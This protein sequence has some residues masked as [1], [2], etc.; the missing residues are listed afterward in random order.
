M[1]AIRP[2]PM[3]TPN[4]SDSFGSILTRGAGSHHHGSAH[5]GSS[6][7]G[8]DLIS[9]D[10]AGAAG[11]VGTHSGHGRGGHASRDSHHFTVAVVGLTSFTAVLIAG[12]CLS[13]GI[14]I[15]Q[16]TAQCVESHI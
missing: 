15:G 12:V 13:C 5:H 16:K 4:G 11:E 3:R 9:E 2:P 7:H 14:A 8:S 10:L 1:A 6:H